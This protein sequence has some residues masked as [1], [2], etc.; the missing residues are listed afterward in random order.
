[1]RTYTATSQQVGAYYDHL[2]TYYRLV[3]GDNL[4]MGYWPTEASDLPLSVAQEN[5]TDLLIN[6]TPVRAGHKVLDVGCGFGRPGVRLAE[7]T[8]CNVLGITVSAVQAEEA[9]CYAQQRGLAQ[10]VSF[11]QMDAMQLPF[12][13]EIFDAVWALESLFHMPNRKE[14]LEQV[15]QVLRVGGH[16]V[17]TDAYD[18]VPYTAQEEEF[19]NEGF[20]AHS[21]ITPDDYRVLLRSLNFRVIEVLDISRHTHPTIPHLMAN[22]AQKAA[23]LKAAYG[24]QFVAQMQQ[25]GPML[26]TLAREKTAYFVLRA[27]KIA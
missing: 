6:L 20:Q 2:A 19:I 23:L 14:V 16:L 3:W 22:T 8:G 12:E 1:M 18:K 9:Q 11:L 13:T 24:E 10:Q 26:D 4:H 17:L 25:A 27:E 5:L 15:A 21:L 7:K